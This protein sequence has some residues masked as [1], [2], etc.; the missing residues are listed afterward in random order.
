MPRSV[1]VYGIYGLLC[2]VNWTHWERPVA[3]NIC[4][5]ELLQTTGSDTWMQPFEST[6]SVYN[7][8][9]IVMIRPHSWT[10]ID[11]NKPTLSR[12]MAPSW[13][14]EPIAGNRVALEQEVI[15]NI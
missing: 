14:Y 1:D 11:E 15:K 10:N 2:H 9:N 4:F 13:P 6:S 7:C 3:F 5:P 8:E 12:N